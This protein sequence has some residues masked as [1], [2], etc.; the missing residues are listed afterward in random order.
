MIFNLIIRI[1]EFLVLCC[2]LNL[3]GFGSM[4]NTPTVCVCVCVDELLSILGFS[5][6]VRKSRSVN[7]CLQWLDF[8][9]NS[10]TVFVDPPKLRPVRMFGHAPVSSCLETAVTFQA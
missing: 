3:K 7:N 10:I 4:E 6:N 2:I 9:P 5:E 1:A 8:D